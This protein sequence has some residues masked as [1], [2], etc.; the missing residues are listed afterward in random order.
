MTLVELEK[1]L[2]VINGLQYQI[3]TQTNNEW[4]V[5]TEPEEADSF[6]FALL[7]R[8]IPFYEQGGMTIIEI[9]RAHV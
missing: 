4:K 1:Q 6:A 5:T 9:G 2:Q 7:N 8:D 3:G